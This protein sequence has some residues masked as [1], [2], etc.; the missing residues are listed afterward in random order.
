MHL[1]DQ[2]LKP[3]QPGKIDSRRARRIAIGLAC[4]AILATVIAALQAG[5]YGAVLVAAI[6]MCCVLLA[7]LTMRNAQ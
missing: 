4:L 5:T 3:S 6:S 7:A 2:L 1:F